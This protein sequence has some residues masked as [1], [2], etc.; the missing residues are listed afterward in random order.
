ML[1]TFVLLAM[2]GLSPAAAAHSRH[3]RHPAKEAGRSSGKSTRRPGRSSGRSARKAALKADDASGTSGG[4]AA[5]KADDASGKSGRKAARKEGTKRAARKLS[6]GRRVA[7]RAAELVGVP[8]SSVST[9]V[10]DDCTGLA[11]LAYQRI[12]VELMGMGQPG[13]NGVTAM[14]RRAEAR[15][16]VHHHRPRAGDLV[17][18]RETYDRNGDGLR[19]D[20]LTHVG[21]VEAV[22]EDGT[23]TFIHRAGGQVKRGRMNL[24]RPAEHGRRK[25]G[26]LNDYLRRATDSERAYL[27][28]ELF[29][30]YA[31]AARM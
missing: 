7:K 22:D 27:T 11:R 19:N 29:A 2:L 18:F 5:L 6:R 20:G 17:F 3:G 10:P 16:A 1:R 15:K 14:Y 21:V 30:G 9:A 25:D 26:I 24:A 13:D 4:K 8:L 28:G 12:G 31:S 23:V